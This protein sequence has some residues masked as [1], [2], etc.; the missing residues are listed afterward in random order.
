MNLITGHDAEIAEW[1]A[2]RIEHA[3]DFGL[4]TAIGVAT[5]SKL[6]AGFVYN[7]Y[8]PSYRTIQMS[9]AAISPVWARWEIIHELFRYPFEQLDVF[10]VWTATPH[11]NERALK[12]NHHIGMKR[13]GVLAHHFGPKRHAVINRMLGPDYRRIFYGE[14]NG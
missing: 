6:I 7:E 8:Q 4:C 11:D 13:E 3:D 12:V 9:G 1:V 2:A 10:K 5:D 14:N